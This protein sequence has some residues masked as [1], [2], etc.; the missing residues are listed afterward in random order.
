MG[1]RFDPDEVEAA[2]EVAA[3]AIRRLN[4]LEYVILF[5]ALALALLGGALVAWVVSSATDLSFRWTWAAASL[6]LFVLP[7]ALVYLRERRRG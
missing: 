3:R 6:L 2:R 5:F 1:R 7:G 4:I